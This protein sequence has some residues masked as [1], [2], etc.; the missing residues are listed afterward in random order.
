MYIGTSPRIPSSQYTSLETRCCGT[1][2]LCANRPVA[3]F[4]CGGILYI[5][6]AV[7]NNLCGSRGMASLCTHKQHRPI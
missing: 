6:V 3:A 5:S 7:G 4:V 1:D 2:I